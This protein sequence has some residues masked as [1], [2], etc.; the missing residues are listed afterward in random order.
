MSGN[1]NEVTE[2]W[3]DHKAIQ[4]KKRASNRLNLA[5]SL[6][7]AGVCYTSHNDG[8]HLVVEHNCLIVDFWPGTGRWKNRKSG[9][10]GFSIKSI[11]KHI[12]IKL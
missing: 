7:S 9:E 11:F 10:Y 12:R 2:M 1:E 3:R 5:R 8:A 6:V 4:S